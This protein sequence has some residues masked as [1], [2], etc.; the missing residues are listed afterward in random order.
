M[1]GEVQFAAIFSLVLMIIPLVTLLPHWVSE[2]KICNRSRWL[3]VAGLCVLL[4][5]FVLQYILKFRAMG[6][7]QAVTLNILMFIPAAAL[8]GL[9]ILNL[10][11]QGELNRRDWLVGLAAWILTIVLIVWASSID[12]QPLLAG[13]DQQ[14]NAIQVAA[15]IY[16]IMQ[17]YYSYTILRELRRMQLVLDDYYASDHNTLLK[18]MKIAIVW[19]SLVSLLSPILIFMSKWVLFLNFWLIFT[20]LFY[21]WCCFTR[22]FISRSVVFVGNA[23]ESAAEDIHH[24]QVA[25]D[26]NSCLPETNN[27]VEKAVEKWIADHG[28]LESGLTSPMAASAMGIPRYLLTAWV[29]EKGYESFTHWVTGLRIEEA[30]LVMK[31]HPDWSNESVADHCGFSRT[32]FQ[33]VF[34]KMT[35]LSPTQYINGI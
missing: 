21:V 1:L 13:S 26:D 11:R 15:C 20:G 10:Q 30:K 29:K 4:I 6:V 5:H 25:V 17:M 19:L 12:G 28:Y 7:I 18:W 35:G 9:A 23:E 3:M 2:N 24:E 16:I 27:R 22:Y 31:E 33:K 34:K 8:I 14:T 32:H